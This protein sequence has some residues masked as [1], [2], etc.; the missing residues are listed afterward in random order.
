L[1][2][3]AINFNG[4]AS[5]VDQNGNIIG[6]ISSYQTSDGKTHEI[7]DVWLQ[8]N[9]SSSQDNGDPIAAIT[10]AITSYVDPST[11]PTSSQSSL[12]VNQNGND[13]TQLAMANVLSSFDS[14][15]NLIV[16]N[17][18]ADPAKSI[19]TNPVTNLLDD[20]TTK[21]SGILGIN[22]NK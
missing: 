7:A 19:L 11:L 2:I 17:Q 3:T 12:P 14:N 9:Q 1:G 18:P 4:S 13:Q 10:K 8:T 22:V 16:S 6:L 5:N 15:G 20:P 21:S